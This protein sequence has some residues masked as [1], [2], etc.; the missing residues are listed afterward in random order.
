MYVHRY[1]WECRHGPI[2]S[3]LHVDHL[4]RNRACGNP[5][6]MEL[7]SPGENVLRGEGP[8]AI[9]A[10]KT[11]CIHGHEYTPENTYHRREGWR[12]CRT[13]RREAKRKR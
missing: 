8:T 10:R 1:M 6:H 2:A 11:H 3:E 13:C 7:V 12:G 5:A 9:N 4:C